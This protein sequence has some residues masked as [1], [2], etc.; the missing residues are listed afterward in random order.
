MS[1]DNSQRLQDILGREKAT[2]DK[3]ALERKEREGQQREAEE[4]KAA[5]VAKWKELQPQLSDLVNE[6]NVQLKGNGLTLV[7]VE[8][9][10]QQRTQISAESWMLKREGQSTNHSQINVSVW[11]NGTVKMAFDARPKETRN[12]PDFSIAGADR[13]IFETLIIDFLDQTIG[14]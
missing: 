2:Q 5:T 6:F 4:I 9:S 3:L 14:E 12:P 7:R 11:N 10:S 8:R 13:T 1:S